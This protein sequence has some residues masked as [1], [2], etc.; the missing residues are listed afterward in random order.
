[1]H[2]K[3][4]VIQKVIEKKIKAIKKLEE[5]YWEEVNEQ[6]EKINSLSPLFD[7]EFDQFFSKFT[8]SFIIGC[9][10]GVVLIRYANLLSKSNTIHIQINEDRLSR[11]TRNLQIPL[12][13]IENGL[14]FNLKN[15]IQISCGTVK[16]KKVIVDE[17]IEIENLNISVYKN[18]DSKISENWEDALTDIKLAIIGLN[19]KVEKPYETSAKEEKDVLIKKLQQ[20]KNEFEQLLCTA[21]REEEIQTFLKDNPFIIQPFSKVI[22]KQKLAD[23]FI[24]DF[25]FANTLDQGVKYTFVEIEKANMPIFTKSGDLHSDFNHANKQTLDWENWLDKNNAY[26]RTKLD[27]LES[28]K[29]LIIAGRSKQFTEQN[30]ELIRTYNRRQN[31]AEF[32]TYDD[33]LSRFDEI[34]KNLESIYFA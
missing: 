20:I 6:R 25:V 28:P 8:H 15:A 33:V 26:L 13:P 34:I 7:N 27:G 9:I 3:L 19:L 4:S 12:M 11:F 2:Q 10:D 30:R 23:D 5:D 29:F 14:N 32:I 18:N 21:N 16:I 22:P 1:M 31:N 24:T 17:K